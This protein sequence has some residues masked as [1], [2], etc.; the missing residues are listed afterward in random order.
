MRFRD[1]RENTKEIPVYQTVVT[2]RADIA[3]ERAFCLNETEAEIFL[4]DLIN[5]ISPSLKVRDIKVNNKGRADGASL[6]EADIAMQGKVATNATIPKPEIQAMV[7]ALVQKAG[8]ANADVKVRGTQKIGTAEEPPPD[9]HDF[10]ELARKA[11][12]ERFKKRQAPVKEAEVGKL[13]PGAR[14]IVTH[15]G[16]TE[17]GE[18]LDIMP[19]DQL[20]EVSLAS[21]CGPVWLPF[22]KILEVLPFQGKSVRER[23]GHL[24]EMN[25][26]MGFEPASPINDQVTDGKIENNLFVAGIDYRSRVMSEDEISK[27]ND[28]QWTKVEDFD[29]DFPG[30]IEALV[31][32]TAEKTSKMGDTEVGPY[33]R[34]VGMG[35]AAHIE[36]APV[37]ANFEDTEYDFGEAFEEGNRIH[38]ILTARTPVEIGAFKHAYESEKD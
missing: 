3:L 11:V 22:C 31:S 18:V 35:A 5:E 28:K 17:E 27:W 30:T 14:V 10:I 8:F 15:T 36:E 7:S 4:R 29:K 1:L 38:V 26:E 2:V 12:S 24:T 34:Q 19:D 20:V 33:E 13:K 23:G 25:D 37:T 9:E 16:F 6:W 21:S 32:Q